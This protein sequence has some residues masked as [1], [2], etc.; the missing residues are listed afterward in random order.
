MLSAR[1]T[2]PPLR[3][4]SE[5]LTHAALE[6]ILERRFPGSLPEGLADALMRVTGGMPHDIAARMGELVDTQA[7]ERGLDGAW[8]LSEKALDNAPPLVRVF[9]FPF[10]DPVDKLLRTLPAQTSGRL[11]QFLAAAVACGDNIPAD[12][13]FMAMQLTRDQADELIDLI[14]EHLVEDAPSATEG[15]TLRAPVFHDWQFSHPGLPGVRV[16]AFLNPLLP[17]AIRDRL[18]ISP[19]AWSA[20]AQSVLGVVKQALPPVTRGLAALHLS[21]LGFLNIVRSASST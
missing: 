8:Q 9:S 11:R 4:A 6:A 18:G 12:A 3:L 1:P 14:D 20:T 13:V 17:A 5:P 15:D 21:L 16:Y 7:I 2:R 19:R 10:Y